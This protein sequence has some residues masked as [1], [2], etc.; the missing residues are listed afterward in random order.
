MPKHITLDDIIKY[1]GY[2]GKPSPV[3]I[4]GATQSRRT[5]ITRAG[6]N[7]EGMVMSFTGAKGEHLSKHMKELPANLQQL[8]KKKAKLVV[9]GGEST[10]FDQ[11]I[12]D[13]A[14]KHNI[15]SAIHRPHGYAEHGA[16][17]YLARNRAIA[18]EGDLL[19]GAVAP[20]TR[21]TLN[22]LVNGLH[23]K[24]PT[25]AFKASEEIPEL[26]RLFA[27]VPK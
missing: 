4:P 10:G 6:G 25:F 23:L 11:M 8:I 21:G 14:A 27:R 9:H 22:T 5:L 16:K 26:L 3:S 1:A 13:F 15:P 7:P 19:I 18:A 24:K 17:S 2:N 20:G 12:E